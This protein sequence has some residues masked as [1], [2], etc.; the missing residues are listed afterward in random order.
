MSGSWFA[1]LPDGK[2]A[3][4]AARELRPSAPCVLT[5]ASGRPWLM[6]RWPDGSLLEVTAGRARASQVRAV[7]AGECAV[8]TAVLRERLGRLRSVTEAGRAAEGLPGCFH[9][10]VSAGGRV[11]AQGTLSGVRRVFRTRLG[12]T[13]V[14]CDRA[15]VLA[16]LTGSGWDGRWLALRLSGMVMPYPLHETVPWNG[17]EAVPSDHALVLE[18]DG[19]PAEVRRWRAPDPEASLAEGAAAVRAALSDAVAA[20]TA[21]G[22]T[23]STDLSGGMDST[24]LAFLAHSHSHS[25]GPDLVTYRFAEGDAGNDDARYARLAAERLPRARH[26]VDRA[27]EGATMFAGLGPETAAPA[28]APVPGPAPMSVSSSSSVS[29]SV[30]VSVSVRAD[31]EPFGWVRSRARIERTARAMADA[32]SRTHLAGHGGDELFRTGSHTHLHDTVRRSPMA[33]LGR[34]RDYRAMARA[35]WPATLRAL[36]DRRDPAREVALLARC[37]TAGTPPTTHSGWRVGWV[38]ELWMPVWATGAALETARS[39]LEAAAEAEP[40]PLAPW[41]EQHEVLLLARCTGGVVAQ[42]DHL[43]RRAAGVALSAPYLDD[44]VLH[45]ALAVRPQD[46]NTPRRYKPLLAE[47]MHG[48][49][50]REVLERR[51][52]GEFSADLYDGWQRNRAAV[53]ALLDD[54]RLA[55]H[56][57]IDPGVLRRTLAGVHVSAAPLGSLDATLA[58]ELWLRSVENTHLSPENTHREEPARGKTPPP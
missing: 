29:S 13:T 57:L 5:H 53:L 41:R 47:A 2:A 37:L 32:G 44:Q 52:K 17:I 39:V 42:A 16:A 7:V 3:A 35:S 27:G 1:V 24:S 30:S 10:I 11:W 46:R 40:R 19:R 51:T 56:G 15:E 8:T 18:P 58:A 20:R 21:G 9:L 12:G 4:P 45:A 22:G 55:A 43:V 34:V 49:V 28:S 33:G 6:G 25:H 31:S 54:S 36:T 48:I 23:V 14:A 50:P 38:P 26:V